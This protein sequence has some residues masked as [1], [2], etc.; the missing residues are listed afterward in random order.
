MG[1]DTLKNVSNGIFYSKLSYCLAVYGNVKGLN[2]TYRG[3][4]R[5]HGLT[6]QDINKLQ[7]LQNNVNRI[8]S[9]AP[10]RTPTEDLLRDTNS[11]SVMQL[12]ALHN[13]ILR[14]SQRY[15]LPILVASRQRN[16]RISPGVCA[17]VSVGGHRGRVY[18][19]TV[20]VLTHTRGRTA[21]QLVRTH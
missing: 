18:P 12:M 11:L 20:A 10:Y 16:G 19:G 15:H 7:V 13:V 8:I 2:E 17:C 21:I 4:N 5:M 9:G 3:P 1:K 6:S 14:S